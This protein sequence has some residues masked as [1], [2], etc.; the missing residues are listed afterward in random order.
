VARWVTVKY[1]WGLAV[2]NAERRF[3]RV[4]IRR[5]SDAALRVKREPKAR[6]A[7]TSPA[8][9]PRPR[10]SSAGG[11]RLDPIFTT[12]TEALASGFGDYVRGKDPEYRYYDDGDGDGVVC[13]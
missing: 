11:G 10:E 6:P 1:R 8:P 4:E 5:C 9:Q 3:L 2:D 12:C 7:P 13:E